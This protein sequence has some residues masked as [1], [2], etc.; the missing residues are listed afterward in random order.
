MCT[1]QVLQLG[2]EL[3][4]EALHLESWSMA[5]VAGQQATEKRNM[6]RQQVG[7]Q[8]SGMAKGHAWHC[9][10]SNP[11]LCPGIYCTCHEGKSIWSKHSSLI[12]SSLHTVSHDFPLTWTSMSVGEF[13]PA[14]GR[15]AHSAASPNRSAQQHPP[16][17]LLTPQ[18]S[19]SS[20]GKSWWKGTMRITMEKCAQ[21]PNITTKY[22]KHTWCILTCQ[23][24]CTPFMEPASISTQVTLVA[25]KHLQCHWQLS[26]WLAAHL[27]ND[28]L[29]LELGAVNLQVKNCEETLNIGVIMT[30][31][32]T[33]H[34]IPLSRHQ[35]IAEAG[36]PNK[37]MIL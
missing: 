9:P 4:T 28:L 15:Q 37:T 5:T 3:G 21:H 32:C 10:S 14:W 34:G 33:T 6:S 18:R 19:L 36:I 13:V 11:L 27:P 25:F 22:N 23:N 17:E 8:R 35:S 20:L 24:M 7:R 12:W 30:P 2:S 26:W 29:I 1:F 31:K 16:L